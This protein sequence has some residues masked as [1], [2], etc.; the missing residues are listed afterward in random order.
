MGPSSWSLDPEQQGGERSISLNLAHNHQLRIISGVGASWVLLGILISLK[1]LLNLVGFFWVECDEKEENWV[2]SSSKKVEIIM[3]KK[4]VLEI[5]YLFYSYVQIVH[6]TP[7]SALEVGVE[8]IT[9]MTPRGKEKQP[10]CN[11]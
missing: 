7:Q 5:E 3:Q 9:W 11:A 6:A 2:G 4:F 1:K 8:I 10:R